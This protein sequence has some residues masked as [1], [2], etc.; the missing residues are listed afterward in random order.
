MKGYDSGRIEV[1]YRMKPC[2][3]SEEGRT[4][5]R[6]EGRKEESRRG[7]RGLMWCLT[8]AKSTSIKSMACPVA[9]FRQGNFKRCFCRGIRASQERKDTVHIG[10]VLWTG[11]KIGFPC[12]WFSF[13]VRR[14]GFSFFLF[15]LLFFFLF[16][17]YEHKR[18]AGR[19]VLLASQSL[20]L[21]ECKNS[22]LGSLS[23]VAVSRWTSRRR[24]AAWKRN[25]NSIIYITNITYIIYVALLSKSDQI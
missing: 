2:V 12:R 11:S 22:R 19:H 17:I 23:T 3:L 21:T 7:G 8:A 10:C 25:S 13:Y 18:H 6:K 14:L 15:L 24:S 5:G 20:K 9:S 4:E 16:F 1:I